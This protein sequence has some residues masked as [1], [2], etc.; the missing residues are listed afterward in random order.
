MKSLEEFREAGVE[1]DNLLDRG[2]DGFIRQD[3][4]VKFRWSSEDPD[5]VEALP[6]VSP[7]YGMNITLN[8]LIEG[9]GVSLAAENREKLTPVFKDET[10]VMIFSVLASRRRKQADALVDSTIEKFRN[11]RLG[12]Y[13]N[14]LALSYMDM[15][16]RSVEAEMEARDSAFGLE[17]TYARYTVLAESYENVGVQA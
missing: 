10:D 9:L 8:E 2:C 3:Q 12:R 5:M 15:A 4:P 13:V 17:T 14:A 11:I 16:V 7:P 1:M 6:P